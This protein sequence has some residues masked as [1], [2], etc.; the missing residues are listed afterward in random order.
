MKLPPADIQNPKSI[1]DETVRLHR[2]FLTLLEA[3][4]KKYLPN[5]DDV[6][7]LAEAIAWSDLD[8]VVSIDKWLPDLKRTAEWLYKIGKNPCQLPA[9]ERNLLWHGVRKFGVRVQAEAD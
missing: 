4:F 5:D 8:L 1:F 6:T 9:Y 2:I 3:G 7:E